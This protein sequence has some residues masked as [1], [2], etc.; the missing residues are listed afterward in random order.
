M[1]TVTM[2]YPITIQVEETPQYAKAYAFNIPDV[3]VVYGSSATTAVKQ[4]K[5]TVMVAV[6]EAIKLSNR[7]YQSRQLIL[8]NDGTA[9]IV[10]ADKGAW[11][12]SI[13]SKDQ[14][15]ASSVWSYETFDATVKAAEKHAV[16]A[17][18]GITW[19]SSF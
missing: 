10:H 4:M 2:Q 11:G 18:G 8:T 1:K 9:L 16:A 13:A 6:D 12:Y 17:Y 15:Y 7:A 14:S 5:K 3:T 19:S